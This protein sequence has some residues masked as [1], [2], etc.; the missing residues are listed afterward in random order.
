MNQ[1]IFYLNQLHRYDFKKL[2]ANYLPKP[3][4]SE[5]ILAQFTDELYFRA[6]QFEL[7][8]FIDSREWIENETID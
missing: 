4:L 8:G 3:V 2:L 6:E 5:E 7:K 1:L